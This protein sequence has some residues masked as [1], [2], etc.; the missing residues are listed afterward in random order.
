MSEPEQG[1]T[2]HLSWWYLVA[3]SLTMVLILPPV[4]DMPPLGPPPLNPNWLQIFMV[5][6]WYLGLAAAPGYI[7]A[8][9]GHYS[10]RRLS[11]WTYL[12]V[13]ASLWTAV[14]S[15]FWGALFSILTVI[16]APFA[17]WSCVLSVLLLKRFYSADVDT[18]SHEEDVGQN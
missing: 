15:S 8:W 18:G 5:T 6:P 2:A 13:A 4:L 14:I 1:R 17:I 3:P 12:W 11:T 9:A 7:Y 10:P 16:V